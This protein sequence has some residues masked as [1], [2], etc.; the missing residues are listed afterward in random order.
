MQHISKVAAV[1][2]KN[3]HQAHANN[4]NSMKSVEVIH[5]EGTFKIRKIFT[6]RSQ[7]PTELVEHPFSSGNAGAT[8][9]SGGGTM[10]PEDIITAAMAG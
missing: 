1:M 10:R 5:L 3:A 6:S 9:I 8:A 7:I 4:Q 2:V